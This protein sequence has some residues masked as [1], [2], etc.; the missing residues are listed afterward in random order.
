[1][2]QY[3][4]APS[5]GLMKRTLQMVSILGAG[6][7]LC[8]CA[9]KNSSESASRPNYYYS[10]PKPGSSTDSASASTEP[11]EMSW[12]RVIVAGTITNLIYQPQADFWDGHQLTA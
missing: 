7:T 1:M 10:H 12:P 8:S 2:N 3:G 5:N 11:A 6:I 4:R 9:T